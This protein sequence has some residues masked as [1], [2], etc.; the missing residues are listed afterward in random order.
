MGL[1]A[2]LDIGAASTKAV[3]V[4]EA[5][6]VQGRSSVRTGADLDGAGQAA[7]QAALAEALACT[8]D[9]AYIAATGYGR[10]Q[11]QARDIQITELTCHARGAFEMFPGT[12]TVIDVGAQ[13]TRVMAVSP[14]GRVAKFKMSERCAAGAGRFLERVARAL[15]LDVGELSALAARSKEP[16]PISSICAVLAESE[17]I[18]L[19]TEGRRVEDIVMGANQSIAD[20]VVALA[21]Q[22]GATP[23][24]AVTGGVSLNEATVRTFESRLGLPVRFSGDSPYAGALGAALLGRVRLFRRRELGAPHQSVEGAA[25]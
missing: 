25:A 19:V 1:I 2:G 11:L 21:R 4:D 10:Y 20:R 9:V 14:E 3:L 15:E 22:V 7:L 6:R 13:N 24:I 23:G 16:Q 8:A 17:I 18:N 12:R 5:G